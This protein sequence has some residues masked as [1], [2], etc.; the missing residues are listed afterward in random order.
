[1]MTIIM[2]MIDD[3]G[4][5]EH[6]HLAVIIC[7]SFVKNPHDN[8]VPI[9]LSKRTNNSK[10]DQLLRDH[11]QHLESNFKRLSHSINKWKKRYEEEILVSNLGAGILAT[12]L[13]AVST[14]ASLL[15]DGK[16]SLLYSISG[17]NASSTKSR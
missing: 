11:Q 16:H 13:Y 15:T 10:G 9:Q 5:V 17:P 3:D 6:L 12:L 7:L 4:E 14:F 2:I 1:M 8:H